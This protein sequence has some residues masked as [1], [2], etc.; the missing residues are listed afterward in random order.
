MKTP[1]PYLK[2]AS[3]NQL[4]RS[5]WFHLSAIL[6]LHLS[7]TTLTIAQYKAWDKTYGGDSDD[8]LKVVQ[9]TRDGG[10]ILGG[11]SDS[12]ISGY[13]TGATLDYGNFY[14]DDYWVVKLDEKKSQ[15]ITFNSIPD[16]TLGDAPFALIAKAT[17][18][19]PITFK[20]ISGPATV[21][22]KII[23]LTG[24]G[25][26]IIQASVAGNASYLSANTTQN[27]EVIVPST[28]VW[29]KTF[30]GHHPD[31]LTA[32]ITTPDG[33]YLL[34]GSSR[35]SIS[36]DKTESNRGTPN[37]FGDFSLDYWVVKTDKAGKKLWDKSFGGNH[38]DQLTTLIATSDGG[39]LLG[40][41][42]DSDKSGDK[43]AV[44]KGATDYWVIKIDGNGNK[45]WD[46]VY[47]GSDADNLTTIFSTEDGGYLLGG[48][49]V[50]GKSGDKSQE[51][52][53][54]MDYWVL[55]IDAAGGKVWDKTY[56]GNKADNLA[57]IVNTTGG[58]YLLG[59]SSASGISGDKSQ[60]ARAFVDYWVIEIDVNGSK[61][62]DKTFGGTKDFYF[63]DFCF[64]EEEEC[65]EYYG[66]SE[67][68]ALVATP[69]GSFLLGGSSNAG[70]GAE[71]SEWSVSYGV[72]GEKATFFSDYWVVKIDNKG[73]KVWDNTYGGIYTYY[74]EDAEDNYFG[75]SRLTSIVATSNGNYLLAGTS[76]SDKGEDKSENN[77]Q[78]EA[79]SYYLDDYWVVQIDGNG[80]KQWDKTIGGFEGDYLSI[81]LYNTEGNYVLAGTS[82][83]GIG[84]NKSELSRNN[85]YSN[86][87]DYWVVNVKVDEDPVASNWDMR[88]GGIGNDNFTSVIKTTDG[89]YLSGGYTNSG[90]SGDKSQGNQG[91]NDYWIV[92]S[93]KNGKKV[94]E[95]RFGSTQDDYL[96]RVIQTQDGG[97]LLAGSSL[98]G[99]SGD[100]SE[101]SRG[102]RDYWLVKVDATGNKQWDKTLGGSGQDELEKV[103]Q[104]AS[105]EYVLGG[106]TT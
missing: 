83:S 65:I 92:K 33:G 79:D 72:P 19:L 70:K 17:S 68:S 28:V 63:D 41:H 64:D 86:I 78:N 22:D 40:G 82:D 81:A 77:L 15:T 51:S 36:G 76:D 100:K 18:G 94:W 67:L 5:C 16:K 29:D 105:G 59:G 42:S 73:N 95:K 35:S 34:G 2:K 85:S 88:Y 37:E 60:A 57:A 20:V 24:A 96:N 25:T 91:K 89:G 47:G 69:D 13:K 53:G 27:F 75:S 62:W 103:I 39:Y 97:Y 12:E 46:K 84:G 9:Q 102:D 26:V 30:G 4:L 90:V 99:K 3:G 11:T 87:Q 1:L 104:L 74:S 50:S 49:S 54:D 48:T 32:M 66:A 106:T 21:K 14:R 58:G 43:D 61:V 31:Q 93:N 80:N 44:L 7:F 45:L 71:K 38:D 98:S 8:N 23:T 6:F 10:Y 101:A 56:G 52:K 55:K